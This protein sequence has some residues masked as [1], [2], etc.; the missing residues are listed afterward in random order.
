MEVKRADEA[1]FGP[2]RD[3]G[4]ALGGL[5]SHAIVF[6]ILGP[7]APDKTDELFSTQLPWWALEMDGK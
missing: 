4:H 2:T 5:N 6:L 7:T 1:I 3:D